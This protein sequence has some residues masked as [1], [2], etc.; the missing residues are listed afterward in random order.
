[1][2]IIVAGGGYAGLACLARL[3]L[4]HFAPNGGRCGQIISTGP[5][6]I[7]KYHRTILNSDLN[8]TLFCKFDDWRPDP[9][10]LFEIFFNGLVFI[11]PNKSTNIWHFQQ[12]SGFDDLIQMRNNCFAMVR[13]R[14]KWI[15][16]ISKR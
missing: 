8:T 11:F 3:D 13:L 2:R 7:R 15:R 16:I 1:M 5:L 4:P 14:M 9:G 12:G 6:I 10:I